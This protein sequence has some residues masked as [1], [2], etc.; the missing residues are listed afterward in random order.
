M[1]EFIRSNHQIIEWLLGLVVVVSSLAVW[2][3]E[4]EPE[5]ASLTVYEIFPPLGLIAFGLMWTHFVMG[6]LRRFADVSAQGSVYKAAS[7]GLVL[8]LI[9]LHP[10][11]FW[12]ALYADGYGLPP[13]SYM[14]AYSSQLLFIALGNIGLFIFLAY[15]FK[16]LFG[17]KSWWKYVEW[18]QIIG[19]AAIFFHAIEL[20]GELRDD[21]YMLLWWFYGL[22]L[23][24]SVLYTNVLHKR[25][26]KAR[27]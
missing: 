23:L 1:K 21:W 15:E 7:M 5:F 25:V 17:E 14:D 10:L 18:E 13:Q 11:L 24:G 3:V 8:A 16:R 9:V 4:R 6:A 19:M 20:G 22:T 26:L 2:L 27:K 12:I